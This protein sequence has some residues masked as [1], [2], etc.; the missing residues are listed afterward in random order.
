[1]KESILNFTQ[2]LDYLTSFEKN[3]VKLGL[4]RITALL[5]LLNINLD[6]QKVIHIAGTNGKGSTS[7]F[8]EQILCSAGYK[9]GLFNS[10]YFLTQTDAIRVDNHNISETDFCNIVVNIKHILQLSGIENTITRFELVTVIAIV[11]FIQSNCDFI[12]LETGLGGTYDSTNIITNTMLAV[13]TKIS[14]DH[15]DFL[16]N[17]IEEIAQN[18]AGII[19]LN[20]MVVLAPQIYSQATNCIVNYAKS[21]NAVLD[22]VVTAHIKSTQIGELWQIQYQGIQVTIPLRGKHQV[23]NAATAI[24]AILSLQKLGLNI[25][26]DH[27]IKGIQQTTH[28]LRLSK[29]SSGPNIYFDGAHNLDA[30]NALVDFIQDISYSKS[31]NN[32]ENGQKN[33]ILKPTINPTSTKIF[34]ILGILKD[35]EY[36]K[37]VCKISTLHPTIFTV[38]P[39]NPRA[40]VAKKLAEEFKKYNIEATPM[41]NIKTAIIHALNLSSTN[42]YIFIAGSL[43]LASEAYKEYQEITQK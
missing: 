7:K 11:Y 28:P 42:D 34:L 8:I 6:N 39:N 4:E 35:K 24:Q 32:T 16:G 14:Y 15:M 9:V 22:I 12:V 31:I 33:N 3:K 5:D 41:P 13:I 37:M 29:V 43:Y 1:M 40:L 17:T 38:T 27:I 23:E 18:K 20:S 36:A 21:K 26:N 19:K 30:I 25:D 10:P 2:A